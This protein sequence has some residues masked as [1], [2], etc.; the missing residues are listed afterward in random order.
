MQESRG[1]RPFKLWDGRRS[2]RKGLVVGSLEELVQRGRDKLGVSVG[3][4]VRLVLESDGTQ[5][6]DAEYFRTL[7]P[8]SILLLLRPGERWLPAGVD[9]IRA[10]N[11]EARVARSLR[12]GLFH[13]DDSR[14]SAFEGSVRRAISPRE[15]RR[16][17]C[18]FLTRAIQRNK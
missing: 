15:A 17:M 13:A 6:E 8:N 3:E 11:Y 12:K 10:G 4:P 7:P 2:V 5:V 18:G 16:C 14:E 1:K 9:V